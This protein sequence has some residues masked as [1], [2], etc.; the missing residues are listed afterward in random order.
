MSKYTISCGTF[1]FRNPEERGLYLL[2]FDDSNQTVSDLG[3]YCRQLNA[4]Q[5]CFD[6]SRNLLYVCDE[7]DGPVGFKA[8]GGRVC[9]FRYDAVNKQLIEVNSIS[10]L[11]TKTCY[12]SMSKTGR[13]LIAANHTGSSAVTKVLRNPDGSYSSSVIYEDG[14][15]IL[16]RL[17][18]DGSL[19]KVVDCVLYPEKLIDGTVRHTHCH[20]INPDPGMTIFYACDKGLDMIYSYQIDEEQGRIIRKAEKTMENL[21]A[22]R[23]T[24]FHPRLPVMYENNETSNILFTFSYDSRNG[25]LDV[26]QRNELITNLHDRMQPSDLAITPDGKHLYAAT[27]SVNRLVIFDVDQEGLLFKR[28]E[29]D[30]GESSIRG[31]RITPD[32]RYLMSC[33]PS[34]GLLGIYAIKEDGSLSTIKEHP[35]ANIGNAIIL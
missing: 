30:T 31:I 6:S 22:P 4:G 10:A 24:C 8:G 35:V 34:D 18:D 26:L 32:G 21:T 2:E 13:Y 5:Q 15:I 29:L 17:N 3:Y 1:N 11:M 14:G 20:S 12:V 27:R 33:S 7:V 28:E 16:I 19:D 9:C 25:E 23:Y